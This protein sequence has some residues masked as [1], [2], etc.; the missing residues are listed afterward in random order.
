MVSRREKRQLMAKLGKAGRK[1]LELLKDIMWTED[2]VKLEQ[3]AKDFEAKGKKIA[4]M[5]VRAAIKTLKTTE[6]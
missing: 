1:E 2:P 3:I 5:G 6:N 4:A